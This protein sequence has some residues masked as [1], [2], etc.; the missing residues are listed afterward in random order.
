MATDLIRTLD[1]EQESREAAALAT[2]YRCGFVDLKSA[3][4]DHELF[5]VVPVD[6]MFRYN[7]VPLSDDAA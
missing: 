1:P 5:K 4:I 2:R 6:L 3:K 7:F